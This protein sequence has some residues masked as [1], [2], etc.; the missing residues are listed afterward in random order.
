LTDAAPARPGRRANL[1]VALV[2]LLSVML[3]LW[4]TVTSAA[5]S[6]PQPAA[7][8]AEDAGAGRQAY[9]QLRDARGN[10]QGQLISL[11]Q[12]Q[13]AGLGAIASHGF[14][15]DRLRLGII[16]SELRVDASHQLPM[17]RWLNVV[18]V[19]TASGKGFP[20]TRLKVGEW[21]LPPMLSRWALEI[22]RWY[23]KRRTEVPPLD[24]MVHDFSVKG[25]TVSAVVS[26]P[27][28][29]G[30][31]DQMAGAISQDIDSSQVVKVYC[32]LSA[33]QKKEPSSDFAEQ[34]RRAFSVDP[35]G[36]SLPGFNRARF[37]A[38]GMLLVSDRVGDFAETARDDIAKCRISPV[39]ASIYGRYDW[40]K[41]W[42][43]SAA[44][45]VGAGVQLSEAV[46]EW[47][48]LSD[49]LAKQSQFAA[50]DP[51]GFSMTDL[52]ADRSGFQTARAAADPERAAQMA[53]QLARA[54]PEQLLPRELTVR[55]ESLTNP[56]FIQRYGGVDDPRFIA[57]VREIDAVIANNGVR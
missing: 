23:V 32:E 53:Q 45:A 52:G 17:K 8:T 36:A 38:L 6:I 21:T 12:A 56:Q 30:L 48:E 39:P 50:G 49:S 18:I 33:R 1:L 4:F 25:G 51:S 43:L 19:A 15:P 20:S 16:G 3:V 27:G 34:V 29:M 44:I 28:K 26:L 11:G 7:P 57:R 22:G 31:V 5:P 10:K 37:V 2:A 13:L 54:T 41:H 24:G 55:E 14:R 47:K 9:W 46:G 42:T 35:A 40:P